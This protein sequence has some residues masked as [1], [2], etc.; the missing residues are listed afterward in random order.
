MGTSIFAGV[1]YD[2]VGPRMVGAIGAFGVFI[3][4]LLM[5]LAIMVPSL[6]N[7]LWFAYPA[8]TI[9]GFTNHYDVY[10]W[11]WLLPEH[12]ATVAALSGAIQCLSDS[13][14]LLAV[15]F[16]NYFGLQL[17]VYF[18]FIACL[19]M[20]A[21]FVA[22]I[23]VP[24]REEIR[25]ISSAAI[26][27]QAAAEASQ[28]D[29]MYGATDDFQ[30]EP[31]SRQVTPPISGFQAAAEASENTFTY[32]ATD[33]IQFNG[34]PMSRQVTPRF[35]VS[36]SRQVTPGLGVSSDLDDSTSSDT[37]WDVCANA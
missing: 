28:N 22:L 19:S 15:L 35:G 26:G 9:F 4:L 8:A 7:L 13:F 21:G 18:A 16:H 24:S 32:G 27:F 25:R 31:M 12:Q 30:S 1:L 3:C 5:A 34:L 29:F 20:M 33:D 37:L 36:T 10:A 23:F 6:N 17:P 14:V 11:L 2:A